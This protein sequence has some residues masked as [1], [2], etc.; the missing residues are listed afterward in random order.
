M[1]LTPAPPQ[2]A[3]EEPK[4]HDADLGTALISL[5]TSAT[6]PSAEVIF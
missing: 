4:V 3:R 6:V 1:Y 5:T 2:P